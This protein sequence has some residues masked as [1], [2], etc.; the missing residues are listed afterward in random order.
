M[1]EAVGGIENP[2]RGDIMMKTKEVKHYKAIRR[3]R[4]LTLL[5]TE[6]EHRRIRANSLLASKPVSLMVRERIADMIG[7]A[8]ASP[9]ATPAASQG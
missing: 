4:Y 9:V 5:V 3:T 7:R 8:T 6:D 2:T 1:R